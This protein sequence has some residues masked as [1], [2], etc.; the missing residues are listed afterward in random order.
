MDL[1]RKMKKRKLMQVVN[2]C[3]D[4]CHSQTEDAEFYS[5]RGGLVPMD[6]S[7]DYEQLEAD[8][9]W[10]ILLCSKCHSENP[11]W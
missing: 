11:Y 3:C 1:L 8:I 10:H 6:Y 9:E 2:C 4:A 7:K 5:I